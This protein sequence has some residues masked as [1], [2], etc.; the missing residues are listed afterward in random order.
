MYAV[1]ACF[2]SRRDLSSSLVTT[3]SAF[4]VISSSLPSTSIGE[5]RPD[6]GTGVKNLWDGI[7]RQRWFCCEIG[8]RLFTPQPPRNSLHSAPIVRPSQGRRGSSSRHAG[9]RRGRTVNPQP[10]LPRRLSAAGC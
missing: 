1:G 10:S 9:A 4:F 8:Q 7:I 2:V 3:S 5:T 6:R